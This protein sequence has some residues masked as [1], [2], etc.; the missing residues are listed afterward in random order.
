MTET[1]YKN[2]NGVHMEM[3]DDEVAELLASQEAADLD[4][5]MTRMHRNGLLDKSDWTQLPNSPLTDEKK[6]EWATHRQ[7]LRDMPAGFTKVS[8]VVFPTPPE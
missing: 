8:E 1:Y 4:F 7:E 3:N 2:V 6:A 5:S